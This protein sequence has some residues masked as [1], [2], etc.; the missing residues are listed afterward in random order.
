MNYTIHSLPPVTMDCGMQEIIGI[1]LAIVI[2]Y[3]MREHSR[4]YMAAVMLATGVSLYVHSFPLM[5][6]VI[7]VSSIVAFLVRR[8]S[9]SRS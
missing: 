6:V 1:V 7:V 2:C 8:C 3:S 4:G 9:P 5:G